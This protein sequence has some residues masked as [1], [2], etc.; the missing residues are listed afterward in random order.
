MEELGKEK[1]GIRAI[2]MHSY[3]DEKGEMVQRQ[4]P[5]S[6]RFGTAHAII[7][8]CQERLRR[9]QKEAFGARCYQYIAS[10]ELGVIS[11]M[12]Y[13]TMGGSQDFS[14]PSPSIKSMATMKAVL[15]QLILPKTL[16]QD[17]QIQSAQWLFSEAI[18]SAVYKHAFVWN[19]GQVSATVEWKHILAVLLLLSSL[20]LRNQCIFTEMKHKKLECLSIISCFATLETKTNTIELHAQL[21]VRIYQVYL[22]KNLIFRFPDSMKVL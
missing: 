18:Q 22:N 16:L 4:S 7:R 5:A 8:L 20:C 15:S 17:L 6:L 9:E 11:I 2:V 13:V 1:N 10:K 3:V 14:V 21:K 19:Q 12:M